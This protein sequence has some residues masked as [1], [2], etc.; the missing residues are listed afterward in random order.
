MSH[1]SFNN[2]PPDVTA[3][4]T[5]FFEAPANVCDECGTMMEA[6]F[7]PSVTGDH[8]FQISADDNA[9]LWFGASVE[10]AMAAPEI[11]S[12]PGWTDS[13]QWNVFESQQSAPIPLEV[14]NLYYLRAVA[15]EG[16][17]GD[18]LAVGIANMDGMSP[19]PVTGADGFIHLYTSIEA[20]SVA[21]SE[22]PPPSAEYETERAKTDAKYAVQVAQNLLAATPAFAVTND[23]AT[24][25]IDAPEAA[26]R[27]RRDHGYKALVI[28]YMGGGAD[29]QNL[30][31]PH[32]QCDDRNGAEQYTATRDTVAL[33]L[34][35][36]RQISAPPGT[37]LCD[38][39][40]LHPRAATLQQL[41][42]DGDAAF[43]ANIGALVKPVTQEQVV[44]KEATVPAGLFAHNLQT[45]GSK[46]LYPQETSG[47]TGVLGRIFKA[48]EDQAAAS[49]ANAIKGQAY[50]IT[51]D[52]TM[53]RGAPH[54]P[55]LLSSHE[56]MLT[57][58]GTETAVQAYNLAER[59]SHLDAFQRLA[60]KKAGS[61][62][63]ET[64][65]DALRKAL[66]ESD[67]IASLLE[68]ASLTQ[69]WQGRR[70]QASVGHG[71]QFI[72]QFKQVAS[73]ISAREAFDAEVD[74]FYVELCCFDS[75]NEM[76]RD[77]DTK[78]VRSLY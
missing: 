63:A 46:T 36:V 72:D 17:G 32:S 73:V 19:I 7:A 66:V 23:P 43:M 3:V 67:R 48:F 42:S 5:D 58:E 16:G 49:G 1:D 61:I 38:T 74:V 76:V 30:L 78:Y 47:G 71:Q 77:T 28:L 24:S 57:Y 37:Q 27:T 59:T 53:F 6:Y 26:P 55:I 69:D 45:Q 68:Q 11:A 75:H 62:F 33:D 65:N 15:N 12:V 60:S 25:D 29:T 44:N 54:E 40:G 13:R 8:I 34:N 64:H 52:R 4:Q 56:G 2:N 50:S 31:V 21:A 10:D 14:G 41:Y 70:G 35:Q 9:H 20:A 18:N 39:M 22:P 51:T